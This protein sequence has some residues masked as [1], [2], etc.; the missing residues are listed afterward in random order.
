[1]SIFV[2]FC[3]FSKNWKNLLVIIH[4]KYHMF[5][6]PII[7]TSYVSNFM[8]YLGSFWSKTKCVIRFTRSFQIL[9]NIDFHD[10]LPTPQARPNVHTFTFDDM[11]SFHNSLPPLRILCNIWIVPKQN[12]LHSNHHN[13]N[14]KVI[15][16]WNVDSSWTN[17]IMFVFH[18]LFVSKSN[19]YSYLH[20]NQQYLDQ[21]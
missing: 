20:L 15:I 3:F 16:E 8:H 14:A 6:I 2:Y 21:K 4:L 5:W 19:P 17:L 9:S 13:T 11:S 12:Q 7:W 1:M 18:L 10:F